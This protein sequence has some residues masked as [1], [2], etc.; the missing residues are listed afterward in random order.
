MRKRKQEHADG[1][2][3]ELWC[4]QTCTGDINDNIQ[5]P[6]EHSK[7]KERQKHESHQIQ[8]TKLRKPS[9]ASETAARKLPADYY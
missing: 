3:L 2:Q 9:T 8:T 7:S 6:K 1:D 5:G 4:A